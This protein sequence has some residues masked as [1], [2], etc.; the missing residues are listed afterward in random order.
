[1]RACLKL[2]AVRGPHVVLAAVLGDHKRRV[3]RPERHPVRL[4]LAQAPQRARGGARAGPRTA[5]VP[6]GARRGRL[7]A[8]RLRRMPAG[9]ALPLAGPARR[10]GH[11]RQMRRRSRGGRGPSRTHWPLGCNAPARV[12]A[13]RTASRVQLRGARRAVT[14]GAAQLRWRCCACP[15]ARRRRWRTALGELLRVLAAVGVRPATR[16]PRGRRGRG[17]SAPARPPG[18]GR[19]AGVLRRP[20]GWA[21]SR[22]CGCWLRRLT[23]RRRAPARG[24]PRAGGGAARRCRG[25]RLRGRALRSGGCRLAVLRAPRSA[26]SAD[27]A[28]AGAPVTLANSSLLRRDY[29][30]KEV[31]FSQP[32]LGPPAAC[33]AC[34]CA[35]GMCASAARAP[36]RPCAAPL[37]AR[38][39]AG[40]RRRAGQAVLG[41]VDQHQLHLAIK[42]LNYLR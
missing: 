19:R 21:A 36:A 6:S 31:C 20:R 41:C 34:S 38:R 37:A 40:W 39:G 26:M 42:H 1:M 9:A 29:V 30:A 3:A 16:A 7:R 24:A 2:C 18:R 11:R 10:R 17:P 5:L 28:R 14:G 32:G 25:I 8:P 13:R 33:H 15:A 23:G 22:A 35:K 4:K 12:R 27:D